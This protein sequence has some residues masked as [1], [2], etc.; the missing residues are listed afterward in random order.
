VLSTS[1]R[2]RNPVSGHSGIRCV[3]ARWRRDY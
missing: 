2:V 1:T 3:Q